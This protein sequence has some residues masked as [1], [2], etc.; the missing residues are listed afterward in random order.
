MGKYKASHLMHGMGWKL[1]KLKEGNRYPDAE[2]AEGPK[3]DEL[4]QTYTKIYHYLNWKFLTVGSN[5]SKRK[6]VKGIYNIQ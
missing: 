1:T 6:T 3:Q 4:R 5:D 2:K